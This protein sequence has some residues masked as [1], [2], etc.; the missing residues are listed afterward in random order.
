MSERPI[1]YFADADEWEAWLVQNHASV[2]GVRLAIAKKGNSVESVTYAGALDVALCWGWI[3]GIKYGL[4]AGYFL[5]TF[6]PR[7][8]KSTWSKVNVAKVAALTEA[9]RMRPEGQ[10]EID[11]AKADGRWDAAYAGAATIEA[12]PELI[13]ALTPAAL[14]FYEK[15]SS[16][17]RFALLFRI[18][19]VKR[20]DTRSRKISEAVAMLERGETIYPQAAR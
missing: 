20:A 2:D 1:L 4:D 12:P 15:L 9:G 19:N 13:A 5:Q 6:V 18:H 14:A 11:R 8:P 10:A 7:R 17:N 3:D 16:Q